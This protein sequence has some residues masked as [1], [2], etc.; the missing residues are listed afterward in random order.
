MYF[1]NEKSV[2]MFINDNILQKLWFS[3][4]LQWKR[5]QWYVVVR[6]EPKIIDDE[7]FKACVRLFLLTEKR[8]TLNPLF[9]AYLRN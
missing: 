8:L 9:G 3:S 4:Y 2:R 6:Q 7:G 1:E 5:P